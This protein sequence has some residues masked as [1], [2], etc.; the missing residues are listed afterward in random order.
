MPRIPPGSLVVELDLSSLE[1]T[2]EILR[3]LYETGVEEAYLTVEPCILDV[4]VDGRV[5]SITYGDL[6]LIIESSDDAWLTK[7]FK[8]IV[9]PTWC[10]Y[11]SIK[12][13]VL[14][15]ALIHFQRRASYE[16]ESFSVLFHEDRIECTR[17]VVPEALRLKYPRGSIVSEIDYESLSRYLHVEESSGRLIL[18][19]CYNGDIKTIAWAS[20]DRGKW[21]LN[22]K[23]YSDTIAP[24]VLRAYIDF[25]L[26]A[27]SS[28]RLGPVVDHLDQ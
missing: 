7:G 11:V 10:E 3:S 16:S 22:I 5:Y 27:M 1:D 6:S 24:I 14:I 9:K 2:I 23:G 21:V 20:R 26:Y 15:D 13:S 18:L 12:P 25:I 28:P 17:V 19:A 4:L 8:K